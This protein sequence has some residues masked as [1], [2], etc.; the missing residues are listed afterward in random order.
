MWKSSCLSVVDI[1]E[2][3]TESSTDFLVNIAGFNAGY[4]W[5]IH[6]SNGGIISFYFAS[7]C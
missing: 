5:E 7:D 6:G 3:G 4:V 1:K 2:S